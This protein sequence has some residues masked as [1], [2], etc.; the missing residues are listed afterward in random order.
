MEAQ[1]Q[2][3]APKRNAQAIEVLRKLNDLGAINLEV[4]V[5]KAAEIKTI[6]GGGGGGAAGF[7]ELEPEDRICYKHYIKIGPRDEIDL[8]S[9]AAEL[10]GLGFEVRRVATK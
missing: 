2:A 5:S 8:V 9:V 7:S 4:L 10:K 3:T 1:A 6:T